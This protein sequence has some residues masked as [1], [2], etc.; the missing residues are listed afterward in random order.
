M[1]VAPARRWRRRARS[2]GRSRAPRSPGSCKAGDPGAL[3]ALATVASALGETCGGFQATLDPEL[4]V[5]GG[6]VA[7]LGEA[8]LAPM[9]AAYTASVPA[10]D[11]H[12]HAEFTIAQLVNDAGVI[13]VADLARTA[14]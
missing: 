13:G 12:P 11:Q 5:I 1:P 7:Q 14:A 2:T 4:F 9:R 10:Y 8:L 6:G 3:E